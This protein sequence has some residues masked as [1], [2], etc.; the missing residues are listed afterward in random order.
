[1]EEY[2]LDIATV[3]T[4]QGWEV[5]MAFPKTEE[6]HSLAAEA[7]EAGIHYE[8]LN[9]AETQIP[10]L[11]EISRKEQALFPVLKQLILPRFQFDFR[12]IPHVFRTLSLLRKLRP[13]AVIIPLPWPDFGMGSM[14]ACALLNIPALVVFQLAPYP[15]SLSKIKQKL[16]QWM[17]RRR[18]K[19]IGVS[20]SNCRCI[21]KS[22]DIS[23]E[24]VS[25]IYNGATFETNADDDASAVR[26]QV[27]RELGLS[28]E[29]RIVL[30]VAHLNEQKGHDFLIPAIP[31]LREE[32]PQLKF[33]W[34]G[35]GEKKETLQKLL[36]EYDVT[37]QVLML[38]YRPDV[39]RM[40]QAADLFVF[41]T[42]YEGQPFALLEAMAYGVPVI[43]TATDGIPEVIEHRTHGLLTRKGDSC[44]L[45]ESLRWA[46]RNEENMRKMADRARRR[47][48][49]FSR[50]N[51]QT[52]TLELLNLFT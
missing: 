8:P 7:V 43:T 14:F 11:S 3:A 2:S 29:T 12:K 36:N 51:M 20:Q 33:V 50:E 38:G 41:P 25:C 49:D 35:D 17:R 37:A 19:W 42:H 27:R 6:L 21:S 47:V 30:T 45:L 24:E 34:V 22:F 13:D 28:D 26:R 4:E 23:P 9:V 44:D 52:K 18:Q 40:L 15:L 31:H 5:H 48:K 16:Y 32:F 46:L 1:M 39:P 10:G